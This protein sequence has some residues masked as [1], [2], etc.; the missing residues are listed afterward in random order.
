[1][2]NK[3]EEITQL[4]LL[5]YHIIRSDHHKDRDCHWAIEKVWSYGNIPK[6]I[7]RH[8]GYVYERFTKEFDTYFYAQNFLISKIKKAI[9]G[10][11]KWARHILNLKEKDKEEYEFN[12]ELAEEIMKLLKEYNYD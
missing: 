7:V 9:E 2:N 4:T 1:M 8:D 6:Y 10:K 3:D 5:W 12:V 11:R